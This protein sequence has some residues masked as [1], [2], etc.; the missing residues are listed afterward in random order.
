MDREKLIEASVSDA[1][2]EKPIRFSIKEKKVITK[3]VTEKVRKYKYIPLV[4]V[5]SMVEKTEEIEIEHKFEISPPTLGKMQILSKLYLQ[6]ELN[7]EKMESEPITEVMRICESKTD[8]ICE[9]MAVSVANTRDELMDA[10]K[11]AETADFFKWNCF[12]QDFANSVIAILTQIDYTNFITSTRL[13]Q[14]LRQN[15]PNIE[16]RADQVE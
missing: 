4:M 3:E 9:F 2:T 13:M 11:Q 15:K 8:L 7:E 16:R 12:P 10:E 1:I 5:D 6:M 14:I